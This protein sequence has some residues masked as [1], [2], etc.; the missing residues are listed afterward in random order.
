MPDANGNYRIRYK[1]Y[2]P[3]EW[4]ENEIAHDEGLCDELTICSHNTYPEGDGSDNWNST[5][6]NSFRLFQRWCSLTAELLDRP[7]LLEAAKSICLQAR[8]GFTALHRD[9]GLLQ[10]CKDFSS[11]QGTKE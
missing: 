8:F 4:K 2:E 10:K 3:G 7:D 11:R 5:N 1:V 6:T 9:R